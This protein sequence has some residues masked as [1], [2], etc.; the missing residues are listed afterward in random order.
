[1]KNPHKKSYR[2][3]NRFFV[4]IGKAISRFLCKFVINAKVTRNDLE[5]KTGKCVIIANHQS[6]IDI[7]PAYTAVPAKTHFVVS[8]AM[9]QT[10]PIAPIM[11]M[12]GAIEKNQFQTSVFDMRR[13]KAV[14]DHDEPLMLY[15]AG[16]MTESG[17]STPIP[18][19]TAK[20]LKWFNADVYVA[21]VNGTYLT[22]PKWA[23]VKRK[24]KITIEIYKL[25]S[26]EDFAALTDEEAA[27]LVTEHL[28]FDAYRHNDEEKVYY[29]NGDN[30]EGLEH[31]LYVCPN[32]KQEFSIWVR[33]KNKLVCEDCGYT[34]KSDNYGI[35]SRVDSGEI[36]YQ[37][38]SD[39][40]AAIE[41][42]VY[43]FVKEHPNFYYETLADIHTI[44]EKKHRYER[45][46]RGK[47]GFDF[48]KFVMEGF[49]ND[50]PFVEEISTQ[51]FPILPFRPGAY[52]E[53]QHGG[54]IY[55]IIP[56]NPS[57]VMKW[58]FTLKATFR[59]K[60]EVK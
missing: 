40:H 32:C 3:P 19:A 54:N 16:L 47:I 10:L 39:W 13:M 20:V 2:K 51:A 1:M 46:G 14:L 41:E 38:P 34:V 43:E 60:H 5:G 48:D 7:L 29:K 21:R 45:V 56:D 17:A 6:V 36:V 27:D 12:C 8:K 52:F 58:I 4:S 50:R 30:V 9:M 49:I 28:S 23:K 42:S 25:A 44:N 57:I 24:G 53:I 31:V 37:Y 18:L 59:L 26:Q 35:L 11:E 33:G 55:R 15:P 22:N